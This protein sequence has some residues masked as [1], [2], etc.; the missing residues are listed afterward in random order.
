MQPVEFAI[1][2]MLAVFTFFFLFNWFLNKRRYRHAILLEKRERIAFHA[3]P[4]V[5]SVWTA[6]LLLFLLVGLNT[7][8]LLVIFPLIYILVSYQVANTIKDKD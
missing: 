1:W 5:G 3:A 6:I 2:A 8:Y 4:W 7:L